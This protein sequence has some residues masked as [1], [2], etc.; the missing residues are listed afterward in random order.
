M[1]ALHVADVDSNPIRSH[2]EMLHG[3]AEGI[4]GVLVVSAYNVAGGNGTITH[5]RPGDVD[6]MVA[7]IDAHSGTPG[8]NVYVGL[9]LMKRS[10]ARGK[11]GKREDVVAVFGLVADMDADTG[12]VGAL[13]SEPSYIVETSPGNQQPV[14]LFDRPLTVAEAAPL[15]AALKRATGSDHGT[16]DVDHV[17]RIPGTLNWPNAAKLKRGRS[18]NA[19]PVRTLQAWDGELINVDVFRK[20]L[21]PWS[22]APASEAGPVQLGELPEVEGI[23]VSERAAALLAANDVD[24]RSKHARA[25]IEQLNFDGHSA[26]EAAALFMAAKGNWLDRYANEQRARTD[27]ERVWGKEVARRE[28]KREANADLAAG[29]VVPQQPANDN[30]PTPAVS[31]VKPRFNVTWFDDIEEGKPKMWTIKGVLGDGEMTT[32]SGLPGTGKSVITGDGC[33]H[34]AAGMDWFGRRVTQGMVAYVAAERRALTERRMLALRQHYGVH[35]VPLVVISGRLDMTSSLVDAKAL[36]DVIKQ[37]STDCGQRCV[38][39]VL[40]TLTR[41]FGPGDQNASKDMS[42]FIAA[43]DELIRLTGAHLTVV[44][45]TAWSGERGKGAIDLDGAVDASFLVSKNAGIYTLKCDG[46]NDGEEGTIAT[47]TMQSVEIAK[48]EDGEPTTAPVVVAGESGATKLAK[49]HEAQNVLA[50][51]QQAIS[52]DGVEPEGACFPDNILVVTEKQWRQAYYETQPSVAQEAL[53]K[54][55]MRAKKSLI[56]KGSIGSVGM[57]AWAIDE[58]GT[59]PGTGTIH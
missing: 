46:A 11:R 19:A 57:W 50:A 7:A 35:E 58:N 32:V 49:G 15:A 28:E 3:L 21:A 42:K 1:T 17:W 48:D 2:V 55:F 44:H 43:C 59:C 36:A 54:R 20:A 29:L 18:P 52:D 27:F 22:S 38:W 26:E 45:H 13:P 8:A 53:K 40:D 25:V 56:E 41:V 23:A 37:A 5:H 24:D 12:N 31:E 10:L 39:I 30:D 4:D 47:F 9:H 33:F 16:A 34:V 51:L 14:W 6:G